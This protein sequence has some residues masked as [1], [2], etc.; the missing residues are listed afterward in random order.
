M[1]KP[2]TPLQTGGPQVDQIQSQ[3]LRNVIKNLI[4]DPDERPKLEKQKRQA[5]AL[6]DHAAIAYFAFALGYSLDH[7]EP[8]DH[9]KAVLELDQAIGLYPSWLMAKFNRG[10]AQIHNERPEGAIKDF[11]DVE[12]LL[13]PRLHL[14]DDGLMV[15]IG[16][17]LLFRAQARILLGIYQ[18][19]MIAA[20][21]IVRAES[22]LIAANTPESKHWLKEIPRRLR[23]ATTTEQLATSPEDVPVIRHPVSLVLGFLSGAVL[24]ALLVAETLVW[25]GKG[26]NEKKVPERTPKTV[27][28]ESP[29]S[30]SQPGPSPS[31]MS[32]DPKGISEN[33]M[34]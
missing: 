29:A 5:M 4:V 12:A 16:K 19:R 15:F 13:F 26:S 1:S 10:V 25:S 6:Q 22:F 33:N 2:D 23:H 20:H 34:P 11:D 21:E 32:Q 9:K 27:Q 14:D 3:E 7:F 18:Q 31:P 30:P 24:L 17:L 8:Y 28:P